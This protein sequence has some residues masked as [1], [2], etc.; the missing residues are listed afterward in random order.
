MTA[1]TSC[2]KIQGGFSERKSIVAVSGD[3]SAGL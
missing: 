3:P 1:V 2:R